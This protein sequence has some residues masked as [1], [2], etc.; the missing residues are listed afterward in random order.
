MLAALGRASLT[1]RELRDLRDVHQQ[2]RTDDLT[3]LPNRR[4]LYEHLDALAAPAA[5]LLLDLDGFKEVNDSVGHAAGD[6]VLAQTPTAS[7]SC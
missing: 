2:A 1:F 4:A 3:G 7:R 6:Q 5:L